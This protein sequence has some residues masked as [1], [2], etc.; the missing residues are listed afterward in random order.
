[1]LPPAWD[2]APSPMEPSWAWLLP[3]GPSLSAPAPP[4][5][6]LAVPAR[7]CRLVPRGRRRR[8]RPVILLTYKSNNPSFVHLYSVGRPGPRLVSI[9]FFPKATALQPS[10]P[11]P[12]PRARGSPNPLCLPLC[13]RVSQVVVRAPRQ[14]L[15]LLV[16]AGQRVPAVVGSHVEGGVDGVGEIGGL[17]RVQGEVGV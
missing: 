10:P 11:G 17:V 9:G 16:R 14:Q 6:A 3:F 8:K 7:R 1:M 13:Q 15:P 5:A 12:A 2:P 4:A